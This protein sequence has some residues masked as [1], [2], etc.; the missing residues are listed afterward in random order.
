MLNDGERAGLSRIGNDRCER[1]RWKG[2]YIDAIW[3]P[4][5]AHSND[6]AFWCH[7][8]QICVGPDGKVVDEYECNETRPCYKPL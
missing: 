6:R 5:V 3:D 8:T 7:Q 1:L 2:M 4:T